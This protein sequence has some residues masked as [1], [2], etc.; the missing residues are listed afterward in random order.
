MKVSEKMKKERLAEETRL[1]EGRQ[2]WVDFMDAKGI[3][4]HENRRPDLMFLAHGPA[5]II[6]E[7]D[8]ESD[9]SD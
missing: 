4:M 5:P 2:G 3:L 6:Q 1:L 9:E 8:I 7:S